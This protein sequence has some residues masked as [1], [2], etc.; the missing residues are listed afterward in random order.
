M[1]Y[2][3]TVSN[4]MWELLQKLM[5]DEKLKDFILVGGTALSLKIGHRKSVDIDLFTTKDFDSQEMLYYLNQKYDAIITESR[6]F[7]N[8]VLTHINDIKVDIVT[9]KYPLLNPVE[10]YEGI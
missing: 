10:M 4:E 7:S 1:L 6:L 3:E 5:K 9:H 8:T 2:K